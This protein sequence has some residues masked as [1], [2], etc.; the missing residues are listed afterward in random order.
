MFQVEIRKVTEEVR[1][2]MIDAESQS[3]ADRLVALGVSNLG[4]SEVGQ[5]CG[6]CC[7]IMVNNKCMNDDATLD[8]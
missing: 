6:T 4:F 1:V 8:D 5:S 3:D 7:E 2:V